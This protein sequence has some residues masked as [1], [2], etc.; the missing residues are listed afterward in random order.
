MRKFQDLAES[1]PDQFIRYEYPKLLD[2]SRQL[3]ADYLHAP[4]DEI[5]FVPNTTVAINT[6]LRNIRFE[7]GDV[8]L[9][10]TTIYGACEKTI[11]YVCETTPATSVKVE[12][13]YP[14][15]DEELVKVFRDTIRHVRQNS[16]TVKV[17]IFD[18]VASLPGVRKPFEQLTAACKEEH[19]LSLIDGA[20]GPGQVPLDLSALEPDFFVGSCHK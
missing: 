4:V 15:S 12:Y 6:V 11:K 17:A 9:Y 10:C 13:T 5:V 7:E 14:L 19:V 18:I 8:I 3:M 1:R 16:L 20:H 2:H